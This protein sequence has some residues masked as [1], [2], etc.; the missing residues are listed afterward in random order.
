MLLIPEECTRS[1]GRGHILDGTAPVVRL[2][3]L[4]WL[5]L[6]YAFYS[7]VYAA[8]GSLVERQDQAQSIALP[9]SL[10]L[11]FGYI[12]ALITVSGGSASALFVAFAYLPPTA[13]FAMPVLVGFGTVSWWEFSASAHISLMATVAV[14]HL[15]GKIYQRAILKLGSWVGLHE[16]LTRD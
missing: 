14:A 1:R 15:A 3:T 10:P 2:S 13:P 4:I 7:W 5:L 9:L 16:L 6:G 12:M 8:A 11:V